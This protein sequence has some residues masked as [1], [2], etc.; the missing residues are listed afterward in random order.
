MFDAWS[1]R[2]HALDISRRSACSRARLR[3]NTGFFAALV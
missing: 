3:E 2:A 1:A